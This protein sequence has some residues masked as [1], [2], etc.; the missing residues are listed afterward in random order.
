MAKF[1]DENTTYPQPILGKGLRN[2]FKK[3]SNLTSIH[4]NR[5]HSVELARQLTLMESQMFC[6]IQSNEMI[7]QESNKTDHVKAMIKKSTQM[8]GWIADTILREKD[9][10]KRSNILKH[11]IK[12]GDVSYITLHFLYTLK[13]IIV[14]IGLSSI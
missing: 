14:N 8:T 6:Q 3:N 10:K 12:V 1:D 4:V 13:L 5:I 2:A 11:W 9:V 7:T